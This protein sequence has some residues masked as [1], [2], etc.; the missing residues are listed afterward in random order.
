MFCAMV[1][2]ALRALVTESSGAVLSGINVQ[3]ELP[4]MTGEKMDRGMAN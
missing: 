3:Q 4:I 2:K 1:H